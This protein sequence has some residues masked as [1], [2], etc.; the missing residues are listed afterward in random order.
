MDPFTAMM[1]AGLV[2][3]GVMSLKGAEEGADAIRKRAA[4]Q[5][6]MTELNKYFAN[7]AAE[8]AIARGQRAVSQVRKNERQVIGAQRAA[9]AGQGVNVSDAS[10]VQLVD[11][12]KTAAAF[13]AITVENNAWREAWGYKAEGLKA[14]MEGQLMDMA[15]QQKA[16]ETLTTGGMQFAD[17]LLRAGK[18]IY[19]NGGGGGSKKSSGGGKYTRGRAATGYFGRRGG[20]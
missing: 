7:R 13:E 10:A 8:D 17:S 15:S 18:T 5:R 20:F 3:Q 4:Y 2:F 9:L 12:T 14:S 11:D 16:D 19:D 1:A 6:H